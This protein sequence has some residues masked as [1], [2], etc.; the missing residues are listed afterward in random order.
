M[1]ELDALVAEE[2]SLCFFVGKNFFFDPLYQHTIDS[3]ERARAK[4]YSTRT[5]EVAEAT[6]TPFAAERA[7]NV[8]ANPNR[9]TLENLS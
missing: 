3:F 6:S 8:T 5:P 4:N 7:K 1:N 9:M 2:T